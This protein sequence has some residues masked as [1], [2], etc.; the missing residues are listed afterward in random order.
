MSEVIPP[1]SLAAKA[2]KLDTFV[3]ELDRLHNLICK[4]TQYKQ[5]KFQFKHIFIWLRLYPVRPELVEGY[6]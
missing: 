6:L 3:S 1:S 5:L 2:L 4:V